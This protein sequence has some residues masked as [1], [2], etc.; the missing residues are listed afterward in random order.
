MLMGIWNGSVQW[1]RLTKF[2]KRMREIENLFSR[3]GAFFSEPTKRSD[4]MSAKN[5]IKNIANK[6][7]SISKQS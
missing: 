2:R 5:K 4:L 1:L 6:F 7:V 3:S